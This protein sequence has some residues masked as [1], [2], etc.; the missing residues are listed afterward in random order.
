M[1]MK[2]WCRR[3]LGVWDSNEDSER[4]SVVAMV[5]MSG[6]MAEGRVGIGHWRLGF[7]NNNNKWWV[8]LCCIYRVL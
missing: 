7:V 4:E 6:K 2:S 5:G 8:V 1:Y 3:M